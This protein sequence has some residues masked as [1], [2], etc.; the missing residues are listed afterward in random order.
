MIGYNVT[1][2]TGGVCAISVGDLSDRYRIHCDPRSNA[3]QSLKLA[4][5]IAELLKKLQC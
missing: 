1:E 4:F 5:L 2:C 3:G